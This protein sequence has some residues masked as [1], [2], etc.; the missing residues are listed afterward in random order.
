MRIISRSTL[1]DYWEKH[2]AAEKPL[3]AWIKTVKAASWRNTSDVKKNFQSASFVG[4]RIVFN[5]GGN[6]FRLVAA[7]AWDVG[8]VYVKFVGT[9]AEYDKINVAKV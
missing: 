1:R 4:D 7:V 5:V 2:R 3:I 9:H 6:N 8:I